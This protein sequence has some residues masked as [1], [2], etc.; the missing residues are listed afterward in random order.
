MLCP[1][2]AKEVALH[3]GEPVVTLGGV[4]L[5]HIRCRATPAVE[6]IAA[7]APVFV[8]SRAKHTWPVVGV[9][10]AALLVGAIACW[11]HAQA[12]VVAPNVVA[13]ASTER[14]SR[15]VLR[16]AHDDPPPPPTVITDQE[17]YPIPIVGGQPITELY[18]SL[19]DWIHPV[20]DADEKMPPEAARWFGADRVGITPRSECGGGHCG[21]DL[22]GPQD[23][24][25]VAV[26]D[27]TIVRLEDHELGIDGRSGRYVRIEHD[28]GTLT[29]YMHLDEI[30]EGLQVGD[31]VDGGQYI[32]KL[33]NTA[34]YGAV[35]HLHFSLEIPNHPG[36]HGDNT[37]T[38]Y[39]NPAPFLVRAHLAPAPDRRH[40]K[41]PA[42]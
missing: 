14:A 7:P 1:G 6:P 24:A 27:G 16:V 19:L 36:L 9:V 18:P 13:I 8:R 41:H 37:D 2:C 26:A 15:P 39:I 42:S 23:R 5:W 34:C 30:A 20:T 28:D 10:S 11:P 29:S 35:A 22:D 38:T 12:S 31:R 17:R 33:G 3:E 4:Q 21:V 40:G 32:G 25:V